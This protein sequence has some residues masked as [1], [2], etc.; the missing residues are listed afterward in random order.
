MLLLLL[1]ALGLGLLVLLVCVYVCVCFFKYDV[2]SGADLTCDDVIQLRLPRRM[3]VCGVCVLC[4]CL[5]VC[6]SV[7]V[8][9]CVLLLQGALL[10][11][12]DSLSR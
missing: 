10:L 5:S 7:C 12:V 9:V 3:C 4:M 6:V 8:I 1:L 2:R 11:E